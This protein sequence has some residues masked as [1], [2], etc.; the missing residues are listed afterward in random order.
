MDNFKLPASPFFEYNEPGYGNALCVYYK[1]GGKQI[2]PFTPGFT[3]LE[4]AA[5]MMAQ[6][7]LNTYGHFSEVNDKWAETFAKTSVIIAKAILEE[8]NK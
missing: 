4:K 6:G 7:R 2:L 8:A 3:K 1:D 5:L